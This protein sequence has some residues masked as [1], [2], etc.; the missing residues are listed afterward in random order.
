MFEK[1]KY[2]KPMIHI[3]VN[4]FFYYLTRLPFHRI[5]LSLCLS[6]PHE[7]ENIQLYVVFMTKDTEI[8]NGRLCYHLV[9]LINYSI[10]Q[11]SP[12]KLCSFM[13]AQN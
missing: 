1:S 10:F 8:A 6:Q 11:K 9:Y 3:T 2:F 4:V 5:C 13:V 7:K 12:L